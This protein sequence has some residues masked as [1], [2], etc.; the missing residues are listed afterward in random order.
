MGAPGE[1]KGGSGNSFV[2]GIFNDNSDS[3][4]HT[5]NNPAP[6]EMCKS[7]Y[8]FGFMSCISMRQCG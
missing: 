3:S 8:E 7:W 5:S 4:G 1:Q 6:R 2:Q